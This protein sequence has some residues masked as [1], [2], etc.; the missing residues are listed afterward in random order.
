MGE[1]TVDVG[2]IN[3]KQGQYRI[4]KTFRGC[5]GGEGLKLEEESD[6]AVRQ[7]R[8]GRDTWFSDPSQLEPGG[9]PLTLWCSPSHACLLLLRF[10]L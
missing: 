8:G 3:R 7:K 2:E 5:S 9:T 4:S 6:V 1:E 10:I